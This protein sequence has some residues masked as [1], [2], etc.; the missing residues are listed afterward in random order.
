MMI[1]NAL[2]Q[3]T[4]IVHLDTERLNPS[5]GGTVRCAEL[6]TKAIGL[7]E[8]GGIPGNFEQSD[9]V[10]ADDCTDP[11]I[12][13]DVNGDGMVNVTDLLAIMDVWGSCDGCPADLND[14]GL[15]NVTDLLIVI[16]NWT[17]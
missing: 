10:N 15:V 8:G 11:A 5:A 12:P 13:G 6:F 3:G 16:G 14:D 1:Q 9:L 7:S 17:V 2:G 4:Y